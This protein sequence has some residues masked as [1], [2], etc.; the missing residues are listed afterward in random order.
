MAAEPGNPQTLPTQRISGAVRVAGHFGELLQGRLGPEGPVALVTLPCPPLAAEAARR[1]GPL[2]LHQTAPVMPPGQFGGFL[3]A[4]GAPAEGSFRLRLEMPLGGGAGASTAARVALAHAAG[5]T[6]PAIVARACLASEGASDPLMFPAPGRLLWASREARVLAELPP[7][8]EMEI[9]GGFFGPPR[10]TDPSDGN[11]AV[12]DDLVSDWQSAPDLTGFA[13]LASASARRC[14]ERRGPAD[15]PTSGLAAALG[16]AGFAI[17]HT[18][19]ARALIF[20][21][22]NVPRGAEERLAAAGFRQILRY[23]L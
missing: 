18:G 2:A 21:P 13:A 17:A 10:R 11:F 14:L 3:R 22:G 15:D 5:V 7:L 6:D 12:I 1:P 4:L 9:L 20:A 19:S 16:A 23:R 8:P